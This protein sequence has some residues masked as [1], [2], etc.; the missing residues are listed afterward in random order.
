M[1]PSPFFYG[2]TKKEGLPDLGKACLGV[3]VIIIHVLETRL[4]KHQLVIGWLSWFLV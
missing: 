2:P 3:C 1:S 4:Q